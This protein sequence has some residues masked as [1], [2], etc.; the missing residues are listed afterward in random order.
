MPDSPPGPLIHLKDNVWY[1]QRDTSPGVTQP[2][3]GVI[4][5]ADSTIL[6]DAG[7]SPRHARRIIT[8]LAAGGFP[9][10]KTIIYTHH[11][12]DHTFGAM[13]FNAEQVI[14][15]Q[16]CDAIL[17]EMAKKQWN[18]TTLQDE[19][20][21]HPEFEVRNTGM[22][23]AI[24]Q[25]H[26]FYVVP[27]TLSFTTSMTLYIDDE[28]TL[29]LAHVGGVHA[30]DSISVWVQGANVMFLGDSYYPPP[31]HLRTPDNADNLALDMMKTFITQDAAVYLD[32]HGDPRTLEEMQ[33]MLDAE[34]A[35]QVI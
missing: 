9:P 14:A 28:T 2:N 33:T 10:V 31:F 17:G 8:E 26:D 16:Q 19:M 4:R 12:W 13:G 15:H 24:H 35:R 1:F 34:I 6:I 22:I 25:W 5:T 3:V 18:Q 20:Q 11:H 29:H 32:G 21:Q 27:P 7:N 30:E 23:S